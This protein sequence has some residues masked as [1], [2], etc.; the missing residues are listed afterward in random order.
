[1]L[2][3][4]MFMSVMMFVAIVGAISGLIFGAIGGFLESTFGE[5]VRAKIMKDVIAA[6]KVMDAM[7]VVTITPLAF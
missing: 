3:W 6:D 1:M 7:P 5:H 2:I 4:E